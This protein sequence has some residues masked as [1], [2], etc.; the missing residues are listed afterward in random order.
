MPEASKIGRQSSSSDDSP[1]ESERTVQLPVIPAKVFILKNRFEDISTLEDD[2]HYINDWEEHF[3][4]YWRIN[5]KNTD[6]HLAVYIAEKSEKMCI[7]GELRIDL[8]GLNAD[9]TEKKLTV[10][11]PVIRELPFKTFGCTQMLE[12]DK[13]EEYTVEDFL[14]ASSIRRK[15]KIINKIKTFDEYK[16]VIGKDIDSFDHAIAK[17]LLKK[18]VELFSE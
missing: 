8:I 18:S 9:T 2:E 16:E 10:T 6:N 7:E 12:W 15:D 1:S 5:L 3:G 13:L 11:L 4:S 17:K 14:E